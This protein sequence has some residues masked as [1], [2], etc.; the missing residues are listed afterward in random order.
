[1]ELKD[2]QT[3]ALAAFEK[4]RNALELAQRDAADDVAYFTERNRPVPDDIRNYPKSAWQKLA[5]S[6]DV[7]LFAGR[8]VDRTAAGGGPIP[9]ICFKVPTGGGKTL[10]AAAAL[11]RL[12]RPTGLV[13]WMVPSNAIYRQTKAALWNR[14]H[15]YRQMLE[16]ASGG[17]VKVLEKDDAFGAG[18]VA[19]YLCVMLVSLQATN[20]KSKKGQEDEKDFLRMNR[21]SGRY[22]AFFPDSDDALGD[23]RLLGQYPDLERNPGNGTV[24]H[25]LVNVFKMLRPVI[26]LDEAH[27]A[28]GKKSEITDEFVA[29]VNRLNPGLVIELSATPSSSRSNLLVDVSGVDLK[30]EEMIKLP[31]NIRAFNNA[32]WQ[33]TL[34]EAHAQLERLDDE[35]VALQQSEGRYIR[36]IAVVRVE[37]IGTE[38][39]DGGRIHSEDVREYLTQN[40]GVPPEAV[41]VQSSNR[42]EL[43]GV[44]LRSEFTPVRWIITQAALMEGWDCPFAY[45]LVVLDNLQAKRA[46]T[47]LTGRVMRQPDAR[48]TG[49]QALDQC[50]VY[51]RTTGAGEAVQFVKA[52]LE[53]E[54]MSGLDDD[55]RSIQSAN[56]KMVSVKMRD[57]FRQ[58]AIFLPKVLHSDGNGGWVDLDY[59]RHILPG[60]NLGA[61]G[62]HDP[63]AAHPNAPQSQGAAV[64]LQLP[65]DGTAKISVT[66]E[67]Y[68]PQELYLDKTAR[69][70]WYARRISDIMPNPF[71]A[72]RVAGEMLQRMRDAQQD[73]AAIYAQRSSQAAQLRQ[74]VTKVL[75]KQAEDV[76]TAKLQGGE[77]RFDLET[78]GHNH[79]VEKSYSIPIEEHDNELQ[80]FG[81][82]VQLSLFAPM[83]ARHFNEL[84]RR[85]AFY[86]E[87]QKALRW[88]HRVAVRQRG[89]YYIQGWRRNRVWPDFVAMAGEVKGKPSI[90]VFETK[91]EHLR[92]NDDTDY[93]E[94]LFAALETTF[95]AGK[96]T[97]N[98]G[99]AKGVFR[100]VFDQ[101]GFPDAESAIS[102]L[103][104]AYNASPATQPWPEAGGGPKL[105]FG[106]DKPG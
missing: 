57:G 42:R 32:E 12:N 30:N 60:L 41:A 87:E 80:R 64:D 92:G 63:Q 89:D 94:R 45:L 25:S 98:D 68:D 101:V 24:K 1:M 14:E 81:K 99:P 97:I 95:N 54:G 74:H 75:D 104:G 13:L 105:G 53:Q 100:L 96:M 49:R 73:D 29:S 56:I 106:K 83:Y 23:G 31:V 77:I 69:V 17:R 4:W 38:Q 79:L 46:I 47:Q 50:Y 20:R 8:Y 91:G 19:S 3:N 35:A 66:D 6:G 18:D 78:G 103:Q 26:V 16:R 40:L 9:H 88:W 71:Q 65:V 48:R 102:K 62:P 82:S 39:R 59:Q 43:D 76:F 10:L 52:G 51:C 90:L 70:S 36:P 58:K 85:F 61:V 67:I 34:N 27:K 5:E 33:Y 2:Y 93:K 55:I 37:R 84:E 7:A 28:Y 15:P 72:A 44:D 22:V 11:E 21:D 86:L